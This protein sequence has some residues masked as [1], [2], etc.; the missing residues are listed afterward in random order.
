ME[1][2]T[3]A[4]TVTDADNIFNISFD[5]VGLDHLRQLSLW[6]KV[7]SICAFIGYICTLITAFFG[8][9]AAGQAD[10]NSAAI[11]VTLRAS[12]VLGAFLVVII[13]G[14]INYFLYRFAVAVG[15]GVQS[16]NAL[17]VNSGFDSLRL[18]FKIIGILLIIGLS[19][20]VLALLVALL[21]TR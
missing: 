15:Q 14:A 6:A 19:I 12:G 17:K 13:G 20:L 21:A 16:M 1:N 8:H 7:T 3:P 9:P 2:R 11:G 5:G 4:G 18:Y 10:E